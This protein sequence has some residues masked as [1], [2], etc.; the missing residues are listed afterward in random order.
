MRAKALGA[1]LRAI[2]V[3][4]TLAFV[5]GCGVF[6]QLN[7]AIDDDLAIIIHYRDTTRIVVADTVVRGTPF[8]VVLDTYGGGCT[9]STV[10]TELGVAGRVALIR[11]YNR[12]RSWPGQGC[13]AVLL[14]LRHTKQLRVDTPGSFTIR[15]IGQ[16]RGFN[17]D[18]NSAPAELTRVITVR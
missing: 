18:G 5:A 16:Q 2:V 15:V 13:D 14:T 12:T 9:R 1:R 4:S 10:R 8:E 7:P 3:V 17:T 6:D 11:P